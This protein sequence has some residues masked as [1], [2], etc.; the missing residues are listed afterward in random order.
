M[1]AEAASE[2]VGGRLPRG[3]RAH[4]DERVR[5]ADGG[6][7]LVG[8]SPTRVLRLSAHAAALLANGTVTVTD[9]ASAHLAE[10]LLDTN[11]AAPDP[12]ILRPVPAFDLTVVIPVRDRAAQL[13][14]ALGAV[15]PLRCV[16]VDDGSDD[17][18][19]VAS[20]AAR[21]GAE[22]VVLPD[23]RGPAAA[24][25]AGLARVR[26]N[27][28]A[29]V[30]SDVT[31]GA[32]Q[33]L[34]LTRHFADPRVVLV[35]PRIVGSTRASR[36]RWFERY[37]EQHS[38]L[39]LGRH[40]AVVRPG[41][42]TGWLPSACLVG[43]TDALRGGFD[44]ALRAGE[45]VDLVWRLVRSGE[46]VCYEPAVE[47]GHDSRSTVSAWLRR[48]AVYGA[49][50]APLAIRHGGAVAPA[51]LSPE[52]A[53]AAAGLLVRS[54]WSTILVPASVAVSARRVARSL[55]VGPERSRLA[56]RLAAGALG[57]AVRQ[58]ASLL[59]RH[60]W[61]AVLATS[62]HRRIRRALL[63]ALAVDTAVALADEHRQPTR[64]PPWLLVA[65]RRLDDLAYGA[66]LWW[67]CACTRSFRAL[68]PRRPRSTSAIPTPPRS[69]HPTERNQ[70]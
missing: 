15:H 24:R 23:N 34:A 65:C 14:R 19:A 4:I 13:D 7:T 41:T 21:H 2:V 51:V 64:L 26:T 37:E 44:P 29:L 62:G 30:D 43:R 50:A 46:R 22:L 68:A 57:W 32:T 3:F 38:S 42:A 12:D 6:R 48:K 45:D 16:V 10:R 11:V 35:G 56:S 28:V 55:P 54:R 47:V 17:P 58:E 9:Q 59:L 31:A 69:P 39:T 61:P 25:N 70:P 63:A 1:T 27:H 5:R 60:W 20:V 40:A 67:G 33:L 66:G 18:G 52:L 53:L 8:G 36:P 49:S